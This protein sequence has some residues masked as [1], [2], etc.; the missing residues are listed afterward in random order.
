MPAHKTITVQNQTWELLPE[1]AVFWRETETMIIADLHL[2]KAGHF[3]KE[4]IAAPVEINRRNLDRLTELLNRWQPESLLILGDLFHSRANREWFEFEEWREGYNSVMIRLVNGNHDV[5]HHSFYRTAA[6]DT[7]P[8]FTTGGFCFLH[9]PQ[10]PHKHP[11][12]DAIT[13]AGHLHP[14]ITIR[15]KGRQSL[16]LP[17]FHISEKTILLPAFGEFTG[18]HRIRPDETDRVFAVVDSRVLEINP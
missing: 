1:K 13:V 9:D 16:R 11:D 8:E 18:L 2:G 17:C 5:L 10:L 15:G 14:G 7:F 3:R 12:R 4:G 6:I